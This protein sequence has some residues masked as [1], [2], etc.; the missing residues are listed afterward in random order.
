MHAGYQWAGTYCGRLHL[1]EATFLLQHLVQ[2][3]TRGVLQYEVHPHLVMEV[4]IQPKNVFVS[5]RKCEAQSEEEEEEK[6]D[7]KE[8]EGGRENNPD[9]RCD[10]ISISLLS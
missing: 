1:T 10:W 8:E 5:V 6:E 4:A 2:L 9:L 7:K 3:S